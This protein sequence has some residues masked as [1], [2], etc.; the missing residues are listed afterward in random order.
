M[1]KSELTS[2]IKE[3]IIE[4]LTNEATIETNPENLPKVK[5]SAGKDDI[6]KVMDEQMDPFNLDVFGYKTK[7]Y[8]VCPGAKAFMDKVMAGDYGDMSDIKQ[9]TIRLAKLHDVLF[10]MEIEALR[11]PNYAAKIIGQAKFVVDTI[12]DQ[13]DMMNKLSNK[14]IP[15]DAVGYLDNHIEIIKDAAK[16]VNEE[17]EPSDAEIKRNK[18]L[19]KAKEELAQLTREMKALA[20]KYKKAEG[21]EK[22]QVLNLLKSKTKLKK[23]LEAI[24]DK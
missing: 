15:M 6:I 18:G 3:E 1:K 8:K 11:D 2:F 24:I 23:E 19:A 16:K 20:R 13:V 14:N 4:M 12:R 7:Y 17:D 22:E 9:E 10:K 21:L 5:Q